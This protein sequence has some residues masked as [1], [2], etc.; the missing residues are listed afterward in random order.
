MKNQNF[1]QNLPKVEQF[2]KPESSAGVS[3]STPASRSIPLYRR[4]LLFF[5]VWLPTD[6]GLVYWNILIMFFIFTQMLMIPLMLSYDPTDD[7]FYY[8]D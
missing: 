5:E 2:S 3:S 7:F 6:I 1:I 8:Q 4:I